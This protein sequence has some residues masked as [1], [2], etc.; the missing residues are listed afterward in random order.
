MYDDDS[1]GRDNDAENIGYIIPTP[2]IKHFITDFERNGHY[3]G[4]PALGIEWQKLENPT[5]RTALG[6]KAGERGVMIRRVEA[7]A[8]VSKVMAEGTILASFDG[9]EISNDGTV[10]FR[11]GERIAFTYLISQKYRGEQATL[12][13]IKN[14]KKTNVKV[15]LEVTRKLIQV[16]GQQPRPSYLIV[17]G[18][19]FTTVSAAYLR[20][21]YGKEYDY[22]AP[23]K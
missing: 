6:M 7:T 21:E 8:P 2:V 12:K 23:V 16:Q 11:H 22:D 13:L 4:F 5:L 17:A 19:V 18:L 9:V 3:T 20:S 1:L 10:P 14:G 15:S